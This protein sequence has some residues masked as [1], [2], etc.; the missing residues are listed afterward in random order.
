MA[1]A[2]GGERREWAEKGKNGPGA[3][4]FLNNFSKGFQKRVERKKKKMTVNSN[5]K[6]VFELGINSTKS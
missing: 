4:K 5:P 1:S 6:L 2:E 3:E